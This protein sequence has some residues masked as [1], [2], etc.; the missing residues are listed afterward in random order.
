MEVPK[1]ARA[2]MGEAPFSGW[3]N[4]ANAANAS[5]LVFINRNHDESS[6]Y[7]AIPVHVIR[8]MFKRLLFFMY[9]LV[10]G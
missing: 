6:S 9:P 3:F 5:L 1:I 4:V 10:A 2:E 7:A 8:A